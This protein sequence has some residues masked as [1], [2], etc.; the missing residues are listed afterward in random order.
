[1]AYD[2]PTS[3]TYTIENVTISTSGVKLHLVGPAG[4][5][6]RIVDMGFVTTTATTAAATELR[7]GTVA[8]PDA[9]A[10]LSVPIQIA[11]TVSTDATLYTSSHNLMPASTYFELTSDGGSTAGAGT[12]ILTVDWF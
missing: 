8:D 10:I 3:V 9:Y 12:I 5:Q 11:N 1:M 2:N 6:G 4:K 7:V